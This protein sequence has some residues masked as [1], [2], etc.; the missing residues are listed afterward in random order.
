M[1]DTL[2]V[3]ECTEYSVLCI[4]QKDHH[5][6]RVCLYHYVCV[7]WRC[8]SH[9]L[10]CLS[11]HVRPRAKL[12]VF[13]VCV[14]CPLCERTHSSGSAKVRLVMALLCLVGTVAAV[15]FTNGMNQHQAGQTGWPKNNQLYS[16]QIDTG[17]TGQGERW[18]CTE[19]TPRT[20]K[21]RRMRPGWETA[22][23]IIIH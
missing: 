13:P 7:C 4:L 20:S 11:P 6:F 1:I 18:R 21:Q 22:G 10:T 2:C 17:W 16:G 12:R 5:P 8:V 9:D 14:L 15:T 19:H 3:C 23:S